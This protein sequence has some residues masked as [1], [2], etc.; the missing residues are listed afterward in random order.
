MGLDITAYRCIEKI[1]CASPDECD[2][3]R[4]WVNTDFA[5]RADGLTDGCY[6]SAEE[7]AFR[8]G[9]YSG[10]SIWRNQLAALAE[11][12]ATAN[13]TDSYYVTYPFSSSAWTMPD[14]TAGLPFYELINFSDCEGV[15]GPETSKKLA[16]D[17]A[18]FDEEASAAFD[19]YSYGKYRDWRKAFELAS[20]GGAVQ[21][22]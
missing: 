21:F 12:P 18:A 2:H 8:A 7:F 11:Y 4:L 20:H 10:Y 9:S 13:R 19:E 3:D 6:R 14:E 16:A 5:Q 1:A 15:I 17:F 22:H